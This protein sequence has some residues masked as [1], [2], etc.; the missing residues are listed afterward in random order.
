LC[1][2]VKKILYYIF[3][4]SL[5]KEITIHDFVSEM[6]QITRWRREIN[7]GYIET[8]TINRLHAISQ[9]YILCYEHI[10]LFYN[11]MIYTYLVDFSRQ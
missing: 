10:N 3:R 1:R 8:E 2:R 9:N 11:H 7:K 6:F 4:I 5:I